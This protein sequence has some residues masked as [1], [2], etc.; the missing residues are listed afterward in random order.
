MKNEI[1]LYRPNELAG[2]VEAGLDEN[3]AWLGGEQYCTQ[4]ALLRQRYHESDYIAHKS[5]KVTSD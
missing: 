4:I 5:S 1:V 3:T 2:H